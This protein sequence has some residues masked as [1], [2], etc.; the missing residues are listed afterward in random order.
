MGSVGAGRLVLGLAV[1]AGAGITAR[2]AM[3]DTI[4]GTIYDNTEY[5]QTSN[6]P[7]ST[8]PFYFFSIG[9]TFQTMG[10]YTSATATYLG[11]GSPQTLPATG[12][13]SFNFQTAGYPSLSALHAIYPFGPYTITASGPAGTEVSKIFYSA[14]Y[15]TSTTPYLT[16]FSSLSGLNPATAVTVNYP[17]FTPNANTNLG[18]TFFTIFNATTGAVVYGNEFLSPSST[19]S[20][21]PANT[22][23]ANTTYEFDLDYSSRLTG[24]DTADGTSTIQGFEVRTDGTFTTGAAPVP[25]PPAVLLLASAVLGLGWMRRYKARG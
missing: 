16:N 22:L 3:A 8:P 17:A 9:A 19:S 24:N 23:A 2:G 1:L 11:P 12:P 21:I 18:L 10:D 25:E 7:P 14:D 5:T 20:T 4:T 15:F 6:S 13:T